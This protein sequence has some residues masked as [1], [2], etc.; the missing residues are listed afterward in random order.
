MRANVAFVITLLFLFKATWT[1]TAA[2]AADP[3]KD[4]Q[5]LVSILAAPSEASSL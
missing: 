3:S 1:G 4:N 5:G 2:A